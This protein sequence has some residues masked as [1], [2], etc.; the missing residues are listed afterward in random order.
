MLTSVIY[1]MMPSKAQGIHLFN[2]MII[3]KY[4][5]GKYVEEGDCCLTIGNT[6]EWVWWF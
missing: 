3:N 4:Q 5:T 1:L 6:L 2:G